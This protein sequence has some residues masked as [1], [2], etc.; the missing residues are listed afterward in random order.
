MRVCEFVC[1]CACR[2]ASVKSFLHMCEYRAVPAMEETSA[3]DV[4][5][6][7]S[8]V[9]GGRRDYIPE[10]RSIVQQLTPHHVVDYLHLRCA[11][12]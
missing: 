5:Q 9:M 7:F 10:L 12:P 1:C 11:V 8:D 6:M 4:F 3:S 2:K